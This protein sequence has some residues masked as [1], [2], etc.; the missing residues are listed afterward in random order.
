MLCKISLFSSPFLIPSAPVRTNFLNCCPRTKL[1]SWSGMPHLSKTPTFSGQIKFTGRTSM[2]QKTKAQT[3]LSCVKWMGPLWILFGNTPNL[4]SYHQGPW[5]PMI[6]RWSVTSPVRFYPENQ[7]ELDFWP[8]QL[9]DWKIDLSIARSLSLKRLHSGIVKLL[10][11]NDKFWNQALCQPDP[12]SIWPKI[13]RK[14]PEKCNAGQRQSLPLSLWQ[15]KR[16]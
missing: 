10:D 5:M 15:D 3:P 16:A 2:E 6:I 9:T 14:K 13:G 12:S 8:S 4:N 1:V 7:W 11:P